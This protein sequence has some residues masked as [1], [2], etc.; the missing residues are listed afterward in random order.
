ME[1]LLIAASVLSGALLALSA[2]AET[3]EFSASIAVGYVAHGDDTTFL[4]GGFGKSPY[5]SDDDGP[6]FVD[7][8]IQFNQPVGA[9]WDA[10]LT[11]S[12]SNNLSPGLGVSEATLT[13]RPLPDSGLRYRIKFGAFRPPVS[14]EHSND[15]WTTQYTVLASA[16]NSWIGEEVGAL[17][18][19]V[20][21]GSDDAANPSGWHWD[22]FASAYYGNDPAGFMLAYDGW[23]FWNGQTRWGDRLDMPDVPLLDY[24]DHQSH[25]AEPYIETDGRPGFY[26]GGTLERGQL[27]RV[28]ALYYDNR[29][30]PNSRN[31]GQWGWHTRFTSLAAQAHLPFDFGLIVQWLSGDSVTWDVPGLG[32][33]TDMDYHTSFVE[34]TRAFANQRVT[35]RYDAFATDDRDAIPMDPNGETGHAWTASYQW[36]F[37]P[38]WLVS[39]EQLWTQGHRTAR[40]LT[41]LDPNYDDRVAMATFR[42]VM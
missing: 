35:V 31:G 13:Y 2:R 33:A 6:T 29:T 1:R 14:F 5:G 23:T 28:R 22:A 27:V 19:E 25:Y 11:L 26:A 39:L 41:G 37:S 20:K 42:W 4:D 7:G 9:D 30:D 17:G 36:Q 16:L 15:G 3:P 8:F 40:T 24:A 21:V 34:L 32:A 38:Q 18:T 12:G 10:K